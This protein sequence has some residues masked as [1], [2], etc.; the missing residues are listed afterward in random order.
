M[1][2]EVR[3]MYYKRHEYF[4]YEFNEPLEANFKM[5]LAEGAFESNPGLCRLVDISPGGCKMLTNYEFP[6]VRGA[7]HLRLTCTLFKEPLTIDG[8]IVWKKKDKEGYQYGMDFIENPLMEKLIVDELKL[9]RQSE[10]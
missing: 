2:S 7:V 9:R 10:K 4:R 6:D 3:D 8:Q 5:L 1:K